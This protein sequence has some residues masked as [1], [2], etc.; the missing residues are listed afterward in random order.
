MHRVRILMGAMCVLFEVI[1]SPRLSPLCF[2]DPCRDW[3]ALE[4][5]IRDNLIDPGPAKERIIGLHGGLV[6]AYTHTVKG[7]ARFF[8]VRGSS[9]ADI[10]GKGGSGFVARGY[11]FYDGNRHGGHPAHDIFIRDKDQDG[12]ADDTGRPAEILAF[13]DGIVVGVNGEWEET[14]EIRGGKYVW[15]FTPA[16]ERYYYYAHLGEVLVQVG[17]MVMAGQRIGLL[18]RTGKNAFKKRSPTHLHFMCLSFD[19]GRMTPCDTYRELLSATMH[20]NP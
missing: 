9:P 7:S 8:P 2:G 11:D 1:L 16:M 6:R 13:T 10:G 3:D 18:G 19:G 17:D 4:K 5:E 15:I 20:G 12:L 14:S